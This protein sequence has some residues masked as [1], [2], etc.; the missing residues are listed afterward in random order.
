V[1]FTLGFDLF[2]IT[3][4]PFLLKTSEEVGVFFL[5]LIEKEELAKVIVEVQEKEGSKK[6]RDK[7]RDRFSGGI[8]SRV[9][10]CIAGRTVLH[11]VVTVSLSIRHG[12]S[13]VD[14]SEGRRRPKCS[15]LDVHF[16]AGIEMYPCGS[17][18]GTCGNGLNPYTANV[19]NMVIL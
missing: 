15:R 8:V 14:R 1:Y 4:F 9:S 11:T 5:F 16:S 12:A 18:G 2:F 6:G 17:N 10:R 13:P 3:Q 19:D 7:K